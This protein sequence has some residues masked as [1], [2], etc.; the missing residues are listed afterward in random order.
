MRAECGSQAWDVPAARAEHTC[1]HLDGCAVTHA[2][3]YAF[4]RQWW[5]NDVLS[6]CVRRRFGSLRLKWLRC[7]HF[8]VD[9][10]PWSAGGC[11]R[12]AV[13]AWGAVAEVPGRHV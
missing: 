3:M 13:G 1:E 5:R 11:T 10:V 4:G 8:G 7:M 9:M 6:L 12:S 2:C